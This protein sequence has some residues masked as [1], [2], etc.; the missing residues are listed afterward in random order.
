M[1]RLACGLIMWLLRNKKRCL[2]APFF[3]A[4]TPAQNHHQPTM[5]QE[6]AKKRDLY[7]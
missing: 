2:R 6:L 1:G 7:T 4:K 5:H 3:M